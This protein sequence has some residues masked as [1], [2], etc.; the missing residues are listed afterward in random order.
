MIAD[1]LKDRFNCVRYPLEE[2]TFFYIK[3]ID[4]RL[5]KWDKTTIKEL[6]AV[7]GLTPHERYANYIERSHQLTLKRAS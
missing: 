5:Y 6:M 4:M 7:R 1:S 3:D 2:M